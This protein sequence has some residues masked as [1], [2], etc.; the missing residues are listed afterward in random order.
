MGITNSFLLWLVV[1]FRDGLE[2][3]PIGV[4]TLLRF[5]LTVAGLDAGELLEPG[6][7]TVLRRVLMLGATV[8]R[9]VLVRLATSTVRLTGAERGRAGFA[10]E[11]DGAGLLLGGLLER[12]LGA[13]LLGAGLLERT[14][15][16]DLLEAG[17][18][19]RTLGADLLG[20]GLLARTL[21][22]DLLGA[23][24]LARTLGAGLLLGGLLGRLFGA[25][26]ALG[27]CRG[28]CL[29]GAAF[30]LSD[31]SP[32]RFAWRPLAAK[33]GAKTNARTKI[34]NNEMFFF[35]INILT[36]PFSGN[37]FAGRRY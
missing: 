11:R 32:P 19:E 6:V 35:L 30:T 20:A 28:D 24:L 3:L 26:R 7:I 22:A 37:F 18:L 25:R 10:A 2:V 34:T 17:L 4:T 21:G 16:A 12:T 13:D 23:G 29:A 15:G 9:L 8:L 33:T 31:R 1:F 14:L 36:T 27:A 5:T